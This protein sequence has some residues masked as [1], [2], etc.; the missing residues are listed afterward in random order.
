MCSTNGWRPGPGVWTP[1]AAC[2]RALALFEQQTG[3]PPLA[4]LNRAAGIAFR[5]RLQHPDRATT[6]KTARDRLTWVKSL[7]K[8]AQIDLELIPRSP[9][10]G[11]DI[12]Q[13]TTHR[14]AGRSVTVTVKARVIA[15]KP[16]F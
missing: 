9:W 6:P 8:H 5:T 14:E 10:E 1:V 4:E 2:K 3:N 7:L 15:K 13:T 16:L 11:L 12:E